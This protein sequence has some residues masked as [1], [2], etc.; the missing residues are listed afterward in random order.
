MSPKDRDGTQ[1]KSAGVGQPPR[2]LYQ[3]S[4]IR[5]VVTEVTKL[6]TQYE[7]VQRDVSETRTDMK[8]V[9]ERLAKLETRV[10]H[11]PTKGFIV[12]VVTTALVIIGGLIAVAPKL[13][14]LAETVDAK[15][16]PAPAPRVDP[17]R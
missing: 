15:S 1:P 13:Q 16:H 2:D 10:D 11:L 14:A 3:T 9:R 5:L 8:D 6:Q 12:V 7:F 4:D 17:P